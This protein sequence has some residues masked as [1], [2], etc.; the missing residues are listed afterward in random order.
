VR[1]HD[2][3]YLVTPINRQNRRDLIVTLY[4]VAIGLRLRPALRRDGVDDASLIR[5]GLRRR[6]FGGEAR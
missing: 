3:A 5:A 1:H 6:E 2:S 4:L